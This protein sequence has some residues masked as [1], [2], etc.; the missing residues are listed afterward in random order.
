MTTVFFCIFL[1]ELTLIIFYANI[2]HFIQFFVDFPTLPHLTWDFMKH[3][4]VP[5]PTLENT[6]S[7]FRKVLKKK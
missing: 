2:L 7:F 4:A 3:N 1:Y 5:I 6:P